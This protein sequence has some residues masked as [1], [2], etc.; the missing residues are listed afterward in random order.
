MVFIIIKLTVTGFCRLNKMY[1]IIR[2][3]Y[4]LNMKAG[5]GVWGV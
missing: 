2:P 4:N 1:S 3:N 5:K